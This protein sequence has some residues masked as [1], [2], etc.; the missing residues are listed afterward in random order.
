MLAGFHWLRLD[1]EGALEALSPCIVPCHPEHGCHML[2][3]PLLVG[4]EQAHITL[5]TAPEHIVLSSELDA[6]VDGVLDLD[7]G[8]CYYVE[9]RVGGCAVHVALVAEYVGGRPE[10][11]DSGLL[12]LHL[13]VIGD[14]CK[15]SL[16]L[17]Y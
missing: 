11:L 9:V 14:S 16:V 2:L 17:L 10:K 12:H 4:V 15:I 5:A 8:A 6:G 3:L 7:N 13:E 1:E